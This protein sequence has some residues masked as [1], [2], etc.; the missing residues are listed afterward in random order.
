[1]V[2]TQEKIL[3]GWQSEWHN[4]VAC[5]FYIGIQCYIDIQWY[6][7]P[8]AHLEVKFGCLGGI[9]FENDPLWLQGE[10]HWFCISFL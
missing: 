4:H 2:V 3:S 1:M 9:F 7:R 10:R 8:M 5:L 6:A